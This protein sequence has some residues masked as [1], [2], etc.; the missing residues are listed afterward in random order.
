MVRTSW[1]YNLKKDELTGACAEFGLEALNTVEEMR[2]ALGVLAGSTNPNDVVDTLTL[3]MDFLNEAQATLVLGERAVQFGNMG[4]RPRESWSGKLGDTITKPAHDITSVRGPALS[5][6]VETKHDVF[7][8]QAPTKRRDNALPTCVDPP[9]EQ[10]IKRIHQTSRNDIKDKSTRRIDLFNMSALL[11][12][13]CTRKHWLLAIV[14][15]PGVSQGKSICLYIVDS[16]KNVVPGAEIVDNVHKFLCREHQRRCKVEVDAHEIFLAVTVVETP[17]QDNLSDCRIHTLKNM[18]R[19]LC[20]GDEP[21]DA[22]DLP[23][24]WYTSQDAKIARIRL[25]QDISALAKANGYKGEIP[26]LKAQPGNLAAIGAGEGVR[27]QT[28]RAVACRAM[29][30]LTTENESAQKVRVLDTRSHCV[31]EDVTSYDTVTPPTSGAAYKTP[32][33]EGVCLGFLIPIDLGKPDEIIK[34][35]RLSM[36]ES[37]YHDDTTFPD[38]NLCR[39]KT[40]SINSW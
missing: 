12:P 14:S 4:Q 31:T 11:L 13:I 20:R 34:G 36:K 23:T 6:V 35:F 9:K 10:R 18:Y 38:V 30:P 15:H 17:Q 27:Q 21:W 40:A 33:T 8:G 32:D 7:I 26:K 22:A 3:G 1:I 16:K 37:C 25:A 28:T 24:N 2:K 39:N 5:P 19:Y 29:T